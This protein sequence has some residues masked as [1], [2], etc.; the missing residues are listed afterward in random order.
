MDIETVREYCLSKRAATEEFPFDDTTLVFKVAG[1]MFA[2][3][4]LEKAD[5]LILKC[6]AEYAL[7]LRE[8]YSAIEPAWHFNKKY[9]NQ[10][11]IS[12]LEEGLL[13][14][15]IDHSYDEVIRKMPRK[16]REEIETLE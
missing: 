6:D 16:L 4:P 10:L 11:R 5:M 8:E 12:E 14:R 3:M 13:K 15:L 9:W 7:E 2:C 1:K